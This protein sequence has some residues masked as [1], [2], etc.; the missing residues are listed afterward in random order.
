L[1]EI[2]KLPVEE[3][4]R[5]IRRLYLQWHPDKNRGDE[6]DTTYIFKWLQNA[7]DDGPQNFR[8]PEDDKPEEVSQV[9][10]LQYETLPNSSL[11]F[12]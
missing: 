5:A 7:I 4:K 11:S 6:E 3:W 2:W 12:N 1:Q 8:F 9:G 10:F